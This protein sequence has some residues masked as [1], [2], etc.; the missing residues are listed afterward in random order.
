MKIR[1]KSDLESIEALASN[2]A[3]VANALAAV[4]SSDRWH[5]I[6]DVL[7]QWTRAEIVSTAVTVKELNGEIESDEAANRDRVED[8]LEATLT[9]FL[10]K[11]EAVKNFEV[12][13][14]GDPRNN[15]P[16]IRVKWNGCP[17]NSFGGGLIL[18]LG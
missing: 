5:E 11:T 18:P 8:E 16:A 9:A 15:G 10:V 6:P 3:F 1:G 14:R 12:T 13:F 2:A 4:T 7:K 17:S